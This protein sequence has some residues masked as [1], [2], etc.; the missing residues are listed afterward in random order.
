[1]SLNRQYSFP[2]FTVLLSLV[3]I[4]IFVAFQ[5]YQLDNT[6]LFKSYSELGAPYA[7]QIY[8]GQ[9][10]GIFTNSFFHLNY[11]HLALNLVGLWLF[12]AYLERRLTFLKFFLL[13]IVASA[14]TSSIQL[15]MT[16]DA[17]IGFSGINLLFMGYILGKSLMSKDF[18]LKHRYLLLIATI[19]GLCIGLYLNL[20]KGF[21][22]SL[23][24][25]TSGLI[26]GYVFGL[27]SCLKSNIPL[28][29]LGKTL[30]I[31]SFISIIY[32]PWSAEW[33]YSKG[34]SAHEAG[35]IS[36]AKR[37]YRKAL[38][39][40]SNHYTSKEN[41]RNI[42]IDELSENAYKAHENE[43]YLTARKYYEELLAIDP[44]NKWAT[45]N[46]SKLPSYKNTRIN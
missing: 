39:I 12:G 41:L 30:L 6:P 42:R 32:S 23:E 18:Q 26:L 21:L 44:K 24:A 16:N 38:E 13:N 5:F 46:I 17:G 31:V 35:K 33:N 25:M 19:L 22:L 15:A 28:I 36:E 43:D 4:A 10:W 37:F 8:N 34:Y 40:D 9:Y 20:Y 7:I 1:M 2:W 14:I 11:T 29:F 3:C 45:E 27:L